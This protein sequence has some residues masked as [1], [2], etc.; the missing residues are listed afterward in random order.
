MVWILV[1]TLQA[2]Y[3]AARGNSA[4]STRAPESFPC[5]FAHRCL[6]PECSFVLTTAWGGRIQSF[7]WLRQAPRLGVSYSHLGGWLVCSQMHPLPPPAPSLL[8]PVVCVSQTLRSASEGQWWA[9]RGQEKGEAE[10]FPF[11]VPRVA[12]PGI[13]GSCC[14]SCLAPAPARQACCGFGF[15][16]WD[17]GKESQGSHLNST[18][19]E[20]VGCTLCDSHF[21][22]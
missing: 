4:I 22:E 17:E 20:A 1:P 12:S 13:S 8:S 6:Q 16:G 10:F 9:F 11:S 18:A 7:S 15:L 19:P 3:I 2:P 5:A 14:A 21:C